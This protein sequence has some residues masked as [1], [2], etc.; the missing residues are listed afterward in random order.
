M[1]QLY[2]FWLRKDVILYTVTELS[3][4]GVT[5]EYIKFTWHGSLH[6]EL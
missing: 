4:E 5:I 1:V 6:N 3:Y 2:K